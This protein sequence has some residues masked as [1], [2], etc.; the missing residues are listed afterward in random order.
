MISRESKLARA[1]EGAHAQCSTNISA[2][3]GAREE[4]SWSEPGVSRVLGAPRQ[5]DVTLDS[6]VFQVS[7]SKRHKRGEQTTH[8]MLPWFC[9]DS[10]FRPSVL[11]STCNSDENLALVYNIEVL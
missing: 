7:C 11:K 9:G 3:D 10:A 4:R 8:N 2:D 6:L 1:R 5:T